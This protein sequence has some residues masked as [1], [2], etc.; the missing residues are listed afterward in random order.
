MTLIGALQ[1]THPRPPS[2][3][4]RRTLL[5]LTV[6]LAVPL[7][8]ARL[9]EVDDELRQTQIA[10]AV[11]AA[12]YLTGVVTDEDLQFGGKKCVRGFAELARSMA[13]LAYQPGGVTVLN[14]HACAHPHPYC[15]A[16]G[17]R[18]AACCT[19]GP[20]CTAAHPDGACP[21]NGCGWCGN[22]CNT[23]GPCCATLVP[24]FGRIVTLTFP[25]GAA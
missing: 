4:L 14:L 2:P 1:T 23:T 11:D 21:D 9:R 16:P 17:A 19:C 6:A 5:P 7:L 12:R 25:G 24:P 15:P 8:I 18:P 13:C 3:F 10:A 20:G 22:G